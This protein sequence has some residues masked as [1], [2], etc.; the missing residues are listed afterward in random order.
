MQ[1]IKPRQ[2]FITRILYVAPTANEVDFSNTLPREFETE[3]ISGFYLCFIVAKN[4]RK[5]L[6]QCNFHLNRALI[7]ILPTFQA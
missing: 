2:L 4:I 5:Q 7:S 3:H 6:V 1:Q